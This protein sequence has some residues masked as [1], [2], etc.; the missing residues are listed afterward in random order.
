MSPS[1]PRSSG[2]GD[3]GGDGEQQHVD[4]VSSFTLSQKRETK[5][6]L[7]Q[8]PA[9]FTAGRAPAHFPFQE[10]L[11]VIS[12]TCISSNVW[13]WSTNHRAAAV[14]PHCL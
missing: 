5:D 2:G 9:P 1:P 14:Q 7:S 6:A 8:M 4:E 11:A 13:N 10:N 12:L 3:G